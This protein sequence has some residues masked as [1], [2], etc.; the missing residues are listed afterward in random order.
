M[1]DLG[2]LRGLYKRRRCPVRGRAAQRRAAEYRACGIKKLLLCSVA[3]E[4]A[5]IGVAYLYTGR[6]RHAKTNA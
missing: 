3:A 1:L 6:D 2:T 5:P 4:S